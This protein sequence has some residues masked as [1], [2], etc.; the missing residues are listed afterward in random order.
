VEPESPEAIA[1]GLRQLAALDPKHRRQFGERGRAYAMAH[2]TW[3]V[4][5][6]RFLETIS[7]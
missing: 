6:K 7:R 1:Q 4:L 5:A 3:P 2:H